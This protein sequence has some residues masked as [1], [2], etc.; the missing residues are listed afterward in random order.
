[1]SA[2]TYAAAKVKHEASQADRCTVGRWYEY[3]STEDCEAFDTIVATS[4][5]THAWKFSQIKDDV[6]FGLT[7]YKVHVNKECSCR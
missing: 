6:P 2:L 4:K 7:T 1:M 3:L 5:V